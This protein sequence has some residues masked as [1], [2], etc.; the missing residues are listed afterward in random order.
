MPPFLTSLAL[1]FIGAAVLSFLVTWG[2]VYVTH[3]VDDDKYKALQ[4][5]DANALNEQMTKDQ[6]AAQAFNMRAA[7]AMEA[8][9]AKLKTL[10]AQRVNQT[11]NLI[12]TFTAE[13]SKDA[14]LA[15]CLA[16]P[17]PAGILQQF[18]R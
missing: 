9:A 18:P 13:G 14:S 17:I 8:T 15:A 7:T 16:M 10:A 1:K 11:Q 4:L 2:A 3:K 5:A 12:N 6:A